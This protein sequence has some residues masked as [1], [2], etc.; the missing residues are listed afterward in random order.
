[1]TCLNLL[2]LILCCGGLFWAFVSPVLADQGR[3]L[4]AIGETEDLTLTQIDREIVRASVGNHDNLDLLQASDQKLQLVSQRILKSLKHV[5]KSTH[6][7]W[8][9]KWVRVLG[10]PTVSLAMVS[11]L[12]TH[13]LTQESLYAEEQVKYPILAQID[14]AAKEETGQRNSEEKEDE[15]VTQFPQL[16]ESIDQVWTNNYNLKNLQIALKNIKLQ[17][18]ELWLN[19][20]SLSGNISFSKT[21]SDVTSKIQFPGG[22]GGFGGFDLG[23]VRSEGLE[24]GLNIPLSIFWSNNALNKAANSQQATIVATKSLLTEQMV[25][26]YIAILQATNDTQVYTNAL[27]VSRHLRDLALKVPDNTDNPFTEKSSSLVSRL[28]SQIAQFSAKVESGKA[29]REA[30]IVSYILL[31]TINP[32]NGQNPGDPD[33]EVDAEGYSPNEVDFEF[34]TRLT[35]E[36]VVLRLTKLAEL[37]KNY[38]PNAE[39]LGQA[40]Q[41]ALDHNPSIAASEKAVDAA[42]AQSSSTRASNWTPSLFAK[43]GIGRTDNDFSETSRFNWSAGASI[44]WTPGSGSRQRRANNNIQ[45]AENN[46]ANQKIVEYAQ[47]RN[48]I[49]DIAAAEAG[50]DLA[51]N[52]AIQTYQERD[53][54]L[55][56]INSNNPNPKD[57]ENA[58][59]IHQDVTESLAAFYRILNNYLAG[60][61]TLNLNTSPRA[62]DVLDDIVEL[63]TVLDEFFDELDQEDSED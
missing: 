54:L 55:N 31:A 23:L 1:M 19:I 47:V 28:E 61:N 2:K 14:E 3:V 24:L 30:A 21:E 63:E 26:D 22:G 11:L 4:T 13:G 38:K 8:L 20:L 18:E 42:I 62:E 27:P 39:D 57:V 44:R 15:E 41:L 10:V 60:V 25:R 17:R 6:S 9:Q 7:L 5:G 58:F 59:E 56:R 51:L 29:Q 40:R 49:A 35:P 34:A 16:S 50:I 43:V 45:T 48:I 37:V 46:Q 52:N 32:E 36:E 12:Q 33:Y 53:L